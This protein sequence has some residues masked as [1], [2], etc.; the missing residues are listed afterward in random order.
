VHARIFGGHVRTQ[1]RPPA[2]LQRQHHLHI[3]PP[4][5]ATHPGCPTLA[6][7]HPHC[8]QRSWHS[9]KDLPLQVSPAGRG[10]AGTKCGCWPAPS[11]QGR[12]GPPPCT[13]AARRRSGSR[14]GTGA[15]TSVAVNGLL[16]L[17]CR[18]CDCKRTRNT[19][20][21][22]G[23]SRVAL[24]CAASTARPQHPPS[25]VCWWLHRSPCTHRLIAPKLLHAGARPAHSCCPWRGC[26]RAAAA[27]AARTTTERAAAMAAAARAAGTVRAAPPG[28]P[29]PSWCW[30]R[31]W[32]RCM[33]SRFLG[34][35]ALVTTASGGGWR[36]SCPRRHPRRSRKGS[37]RR[38][39]AAG[40][41]ALGG[42]AGGG[43][44]GG[45]G[46]Q[47]AG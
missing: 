14:W 45:K 15:G 42:V 18:R 12:R 39:V 31:S 26:Q 4:L 24:S 43:A 3:K 41:R 44:G 20:Q 32:V 13:A 34:S 37:S 40:P 30:R 28:P 22:A 29:C 46:R 19:R 10:T 33:T 16:V 2:G 35:R 25:R 23:C 36:G 7:Q 11:C 8:H 38:R 17:R 5:T 6:P 27:A 1:Q 21:G 9:L 47:W